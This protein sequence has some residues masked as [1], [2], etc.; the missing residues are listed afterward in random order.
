VSTSTQI[1]QRRLRLSVIA[2]MS[3]S[4]LAFSLQEG[5]A[6]LVVVTTACAVGWWM[7]ERGGGISMPRWTT[8]ILLVAMLATAVLRGWMER[9]AISSFQWL[10][11][12]VLIVKIWER[13][14]AGDYGQ[15]LTVCIFLT[16][17]ATLSDVSLPLGLIL[18][19]Q[20]LLLPSAV[21]WYQL[22]AASERAPHSDAHMDS[23]TPARL[24]RSVR[25]WSLT[26][27]TV[28]LTIAVGVFIFV[29]R[30][31]GMGQFGEMASTSRVTGFRD[32]IDL[33]LG[34]VISESQAPV[35]ELRVSDGFERPIGSDSRTWYLRGAVL[36]TYRNG[37]W[38]R[39]PEGA[40]DPTSLR[41]LTRAITEAQL[42]RNREEPTSP[43]PRRVILQQVRMLQGISGESSL[44][45]LHRPL[46]ASVP[47][48]G[49]LWY[50]TQTGGVVLRDAPRDLTYSIRSLPE[51]DDSRVTRDARGLVSF[52]SEIVYEEAARVLAQAGIP[53]DP[54]ERN[55]SDDSRALRVLEAHLRTAF[56]YTLQGTPPPLNAEPI[57][58][59]LR[60][61]RRG[62][63]EQ[64]AAALAAMS[65][66]S[67]IQARVVAGYV[68]NEYDEARDLYIVRAA[69]AHAWVEAQ[70]APGIWRTFDPTPPASLTQARQRQTGLRALFARA[71]DQIQSAW[72]SRFIGFDLSAQNQI[73]SGDGARR[74]WFMAI[75]EWAGT[76]SGRRGGVRP[77]SGWRNLLY[78]IVGGAV[79]LIALR[80]AIAFYK[81]F[82]VRSYRVS[83]GRLLDLPPH[84]RTLHA[85][86][87][88][89]MK[90]VDPAS[91][92]DGSLPLL[93]RTQALVSQHGQPVLP[94]LDAAH[95]LYGSAF[96][97]HRIS[98]ESASA[99]LAKVKRV[100]RPVPLVT[101]APPG[102]YPATATP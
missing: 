92:V 85:A 57:E 65:L 86:V 32:S 94:L 60:D 49:D 88:R 12:L 19:A 40:N 99:L 83:D 91:A 5:A 35:L 24:R 30:G 36:D 17:G 81:R 26:T 102:P 62:H 13:R 45:S 4:L 38:S 42:W 66:A 72:S 23:Q 75:D 43:D 59:F 28:G 22:H 31:I 80:G 90:R 21:M 64:F 82:S 100:R 9:D 52:P 53:I 11:A 44:F 51:L 68:A 84:E 74:P 73:F 10:L 63:C 101:N 78:W 27:V 37:A 18:L 87:R 67:G 93:H 50:D 33:N 15:I 41:R 46:W 6:V 2:M 34:G 8:N 58:W 76:P 61:S 16:I 79:G 54:R 20:A 89:A 96:G 48:G 55:R 71:T 1:I 14:R 69:N 56:S 47:G 25:R 95:A 7:N 98:P 97:G 29:P 39:V 70:I 77:G 3:L